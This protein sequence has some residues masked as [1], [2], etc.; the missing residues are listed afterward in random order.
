MI[1]FI[2]ALSYDVDF[3]RELK[4]GMKFTV[5]LEQ[6]VTSDGKVTHPGRLLAG[7]LQLGKR[8]VTVHPL[9]AAGRRRPVLQPAGRECRALLPA[10]ADGCVAH[11][12]A[13][14][15]A[16]ASDPGLQCVARGVDFAAPSGTPILAAGAGKVTS[17]PGR[18]AATVSS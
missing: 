6:L 3:Q 8:T 13:L 1:E 11:H 5:L 7:E 16:R 15:P 9:P 12:V 18:T 10:H 2:R 14:R 17:W 4:Q